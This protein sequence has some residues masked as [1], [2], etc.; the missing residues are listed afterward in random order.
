MLRKIL[1][2]VSYQS[3]NLKIPIVDIEPFLQGK[4][5]PEECKIVADSFYKFGCLIIKDPRVN[6]E[7]NSA[8]IDM[9]EKMFSKR[10]A[11]HYAGRKVED[12]FPEHDFEVG[13][14]PEFV[15]RVRCNEEEMK[16][17]TS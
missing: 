2:K 6:Q 7:Q 8:F 10:A 1:S 9:M 11:D 14:T 12:I 16:K 15:E 17:Y 13:I 3:S 4:T 5:C